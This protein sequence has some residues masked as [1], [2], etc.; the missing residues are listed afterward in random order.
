MT[1]KINFVGTRPNTSA[2]FWWESNDPAI[3]NYRQI[4]NNQASS[5]GITATETISSDQ[6][7]YTVSYVAETPEIWS[8][9]RAQAATDVK[10]FRDNYFTSNNHKLSVNVINDE[11]GEIIKNIVIIA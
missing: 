1:I 8:S 4:V 2:M 5:L 3:V 7:T 10:T 11:T 6:L 9:F